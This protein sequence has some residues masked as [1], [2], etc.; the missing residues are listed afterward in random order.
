MALLPNMSS[1]K[2]Q[3]PPEPIGWPLLP[4]PDEHGALQYPTL[5][6]SLRAQII[7]ILRTGQG[8]Q[9][10]HPDFGT[11]IETM[12]YEP[13]TLATRARIREQIVEGLK[14]WEPRIAVQQ[15]DVDPTPDAREVRVKIDYLIART[16]TA[17]VLALRMPLGGG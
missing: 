17:Q 13:N 10:M 2:P 16:G 14:A 1:S 15:V 4:V 9:L 11:G 3:L 12:L 5:P 7:V 8:E 6:E